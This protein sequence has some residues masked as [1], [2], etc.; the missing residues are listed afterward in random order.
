MSFNLRL[1]LK[2]L[3]NNIYRTI[4]TIFGLILSISMI[5]FILSAIISFNKTEFNESVTELGFQDFSIDGVDEGFF[6]ELLLTKNISRLTRVNTEKTALLY[7]KVAEKKEFLSNFLIKDVEGD[8]FDYFFKKKLVD[9]RLPLNDNEAIVPYSLKESVEEFNQLDKNISLSV[10]NSKDFEKFYEGFKFFEGDI[11]SSNLEKL[12]AIRGLGF[13]RYIK[14]NFSTNAY[15]YGEEKIKI[16]GYYSSGDFSNAIIYDDINKDKKELDHYYGEIIRIKE[17]KSDNFG[18]EGLYSNYNLADETIKNLENLSKKHASNIN[19]VNNDRLVLLKHS[20]MFNSQGSFLFTFILILLIII[21]IYVFVL[22]IFT[23]N[24]KDKLR[25]VSLLRAVGS[26]NKQMLKTFF[27]EGLFYLIFSFPI[28]YFLGQFALKKVINYTQYIFDNNISGLFINVSYANSTLVF[29]ISLGLSIFVI[30]T[31]QTLAALNL[32]K[33]SPIK[34]INNIFEYDKQVKQKKYQLFIKKIFGFDAYLSV[35]YAVKDKVKFTIT[36]V[37]IA[38]SISIFVIASFM[39]KTFDIQVEKIVEKSPD[40]YGVLES[41]DSY[42][43]NTFLKD[44]E[45]IDSFEANHHISYAKVILSDEKGQLKNKSNV[46]I[47]LDDQEFDEKF[48]EHKNHQKLALVTNP[49][50]EGVINYNSIA[51]LPMGNAFSPTKNF[52]AGFNEGLEK[53]TFNLKLVKKTSMEILSYMKDFEK[54]DNV[55][56]VKMSDFDK[57]SKKEFNFN[58]IIE[59]CKYDDNPMFE[60]RFMSF[61]VKYPSFKIDSYDLPIVHLISIYSNGLVAIIIL[62]TILNVFNTTYNNI[63]TKK[64]DF[65]LIRAVGIEDYRITRI[66]IN[67][68][69]MPVALAALISF[70]IITISISCIY[71]LQYKNTS[72]QVLS[73]LYPLTTYMVSLIVTFLIVYGASKIQIK[74]FGL[75]DAG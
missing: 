70:L 49:I 4:L 50:N 10:V 22:N 19:F 2:Y 75:R 13:D 5:V 62:V 52:K 7:R 64:R 1:I 59:L 9:G 46:L 18:V 66:I 26:T 35:R 53:F 72:G 57:L 32:Y 47:L 3:K 38:L 74:S 69:M 20:K 63:M 28:A 30:F 25:D 39:I 15:N 23:T 55:L 40:A 27:M 21:S 34:T 31:S 11:N 29:I 58:D 68:S 61:L 56:L 45:H 12:H 48:P 43:T 36:T 33:S 65:Y 51:I 6:K 41:Q 17:I 24:F 60:D 8:Y 54:Y 44:M 71:S 67:Q 16:V 37:S 14:N 42:Q 73:V